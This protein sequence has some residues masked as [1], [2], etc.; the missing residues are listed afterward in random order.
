VLGMLGAW[1][2][3]RGWVRWGRR[4]WLGFAALALVGQACALWWF[5][6]HGSF[7]GNGRWRAVWPLVEGSLWAAVVVAWVA[8]LQGVSGRGWRWLAMPGLVSYSVYLLHF[9]VVAAVK[10]RHWGNSVGEA[11]LLTF[12]VVVPIVAV[13]ATLAYFVVERPFMEMRVRYLSDRDAAAT[14]ST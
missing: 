13:V 5:N 8:A 14:A 10:T 4:L 7:F 1:V 3:R 11:A 9:P 12:G 6:R 2:L